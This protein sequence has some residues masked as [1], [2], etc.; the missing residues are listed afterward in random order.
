M[1]L[2]Q[3]NAWASL[4]RTSASF[5]FLFFP[6][7]LQLQVET[8]T[9]SDFISEL[10]VTELEYEGRCSHQYPAF[11]RKKAIYSCPRKVFPRVESFWVTS[12]SY[13]LLKLLNFLR[14]RRKCKWQRSI[15]LLPLWNK[16]HIVLFH[17]KLCVFRLLNLL[18]CFHLH[19]TTSSANLWATPQEPWKI[20]MI[21]EILVILRSILTFACTCLVY[22][23]FCKFI[24]NGWQ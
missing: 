13:S 2:T 21:P 5:P 23:F 22:L 7:S 9:A 19:Y 10:Q 14:A 8:N 6:S 11:L 18:S 4:P 1:I 17:W 15:L 20:T 16:Q 12:W 24:D 3:K